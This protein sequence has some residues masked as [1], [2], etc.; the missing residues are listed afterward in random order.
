MEQENLMKAVLLD[1]CLEH[2]V[3]ITCENKL[4]KKVS[5]GQE[6]LNTKLLVHEEFAG[7]IRTYIFFKETKF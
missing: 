7:G 2:K 3:D 4:R 1:L 5:P 6:F